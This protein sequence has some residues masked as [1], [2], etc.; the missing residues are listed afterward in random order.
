VTIVLP[1]HPLAAGLT[2]TQKVSD[3]LFSLGYGK[4]PADGEMVTVATVPGQADKA[5]LFA[6]DKAAKMFSGYAKARRAAFGISDTA[7]PELTAEGWALFD[8]AINWLTYKN[9]PP[10]VEA[11]ADRA[12]V[13]GMAIGLAGTASDDGLPN[14]PG[15][16]TATW[17]VVKAPEGGTVSFG[18]P[19]ALSTTA[20]F[21]VAGAYELRLTVTDDEAW[22][23]DDLDVL[24][25]AA[26]AANEA[27]VVLAGPDQAVS[28]PASV[29][30]TGV[31]ADD[32]LPVPPGL[33]RATWSKL[34]GKGLVTFDDPEALATTAHFSRPGAYV[35]RLSVSDGVLSATDDVA[36]AADAS[37][38]LVTGAEPTSGDQAIEARLAALG[39]SVRRLASS[40]AAAPDAQRQSVVVLAPTATD[41]GAKFKDVTVPVILMREDVADDMGL[42]ASPQT[43]AD[44]TQLSIVRPDHSLAAHLS[45]TVTVAGTAGTFGWADPP[46]SRA[47]EVATVLGFPNRVVIFAYETEAPMYQGKA[48]ARRVFIGL[49]DTSVASLTADG[50][51]LFDAAVE[52]ATAINVPVYVDAG[53][54]RGMVY[55]GEPVT[56]SLDGTV[57]DDGQPQPPGA[58]TSTWSLVSSPA[59]S[60]VTIASPAS[61]DTAV[62]LSAPGVYL[63]RLRATDGAFTAFDT[64]RVDVFLPVYV[65]RPPT[66]NAGADQ[67]LRYPER[68]ELKGT[69]SDDDWPGALT[70]TWSLVFGPAGAT[71]TFANFEA[72]ETTATFS[73]GGIYTLRLTVNDGEAEASDDIV[74]TVKARQALF[75]AH[76]PI[77]ENQNSLWARARLEGLGF[78]VTVKNGTAVATDAE[79]KDLVVISSS[80]QATDPGTNFRN[81]A[82]PLVVWKS[83]VY[84]LLRMTGQTLDTHF[85]TIQDDPPEKLTIALPTH[86]L[87]AGLSGVPT[88]TDG[89]APGWAWGVPGASAITVATLHSDATKA[90]IFAYEKGQPMFGID[91]PAR[92]VGFFF[93]GEALNENGRKLFDA[94]VDWATSKPIPALFVTTAQPGEADAAIK[95]HMA[96]SG[97]SVTVVT[98]EAVT[99]ADTAGK[100]VVLISE[101]A[102]SAAMGARLRDVAAPVVLWDQGLFGP[103]GLTGTQLETDFGTLTDQTGV[104]ICCGEH[105]LSGGLE[106]T[107]VIVATE[108][109]VFGWGRP[110]ASAEIIG[111]YASDPDTYAWDPDRALVFGYDAGVEMAGAVVAP[112]RR[113]GLFMSGDTAESFNANGWTLFDAG[114]IWA[115]SGDPD[116]DGLSSLQEFGL[117]TNPHAADSDGDGVRD[118]LEVTSSEDPT[119]LDADGDGVTNAQEAELGTDPFRRDTDG[120]GEIDSVDCYP[121]DATRWECPEPTQNDGTPPVITLTEPTNVSLPNP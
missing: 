91:A 110:M 51:A 49:G 93:G 47:I 94:A 30:L 29:A 20:T 38:L 114:L 42:A 107:P 18:S 3:V 74:V 68:A 6:Y 117:G 27:P 69:A 26:S 10:S 40:A 90:V 8:A 73:A 64:V 39:F 59:G 75:I 99:A 103:M 101:T 55:L 104:S 9:R 109:S 41:L 119:N 12:A 44:L 5:A 97:Y 24:V 53:P 43:A 50:A 77:E 13:A 22:A 80:V 46:E 87:A 16:L 37:A 21:S 115:M 120:D 118:D 32:G 36:I 78:I 79:G 56:A 62:E 81:V 121:L 106:G 102:N 108:A 92:R 25:A 7:A 17:S 116:G 4:A 58:T 35:L 14:P 83:Q 88:V 111:T 85:G 52:W 112:D 57:I 23:S 63:F 71:V 45:G 89:S 82:V 28:W 72:L 95:S 2:G 96:A 86:A 33:L 84:G 31:A 66:V 98:P 1:G 19:G 105:P 65:N 11:G 67:T 60:T 113:L 76:T 34:S 54:D 100:M 15:A 61:V 70:A 48:L